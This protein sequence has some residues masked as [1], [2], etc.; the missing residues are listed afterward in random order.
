[1]RFF[2]TNLGPQNIILGYPWFAASQPKID[3]AKGWMDYAQLPVVLRT[4]NS[5]SLKT[6]PRNAPRV[7]K[8]DAI[9]VGYVAFPTKG[10]TAASR[11]AE[12]HDKPNTDPLPDKYKRHAHVFGEKESQHFPGPRLWDHAIELKSGAPSTIPG[13]IY[14]LTQTEQEA[15]TKFV[16]E[17]LKKGYIKPSKSPYASPFFFIKKKDGKLRPVQDYRKVNEWTIKNRYPLPLIPE[18]IARVKGAALFTKFDVR[19]GYNNVRINNGDQWKAAFITNQGLFEPN[20]MFFGLTNSPATFQ[21]MMNAIFQEE[22]REGWLTIYMDD[23]LIHTKKDVPLHR[24]LVHCVLDK[25]QCHDLFLKPEKCLFEQS[26]M[27]F[28]G[29]VLENGTIRMDPTKIKGVADWP[30]LIPA[31]SSGRRVVDGYVRVGPNRWSR[32]SDVSGV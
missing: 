17:H 2:L 20:V 23:M 11:L 30:S 8:K 24:K 26:T 5:R 6:L 9:Y 1:M 16:D 22:L 15:L 13:K 28:L 3:W 25:L 10:Q 12:E 14:A 21:T 31:V 4:S 32:R 18:L 7:K 19:W 27:E 29:V